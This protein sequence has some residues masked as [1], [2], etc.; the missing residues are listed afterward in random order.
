MAS[1]EEISDRSANQSQAA[2]FKEWGVVNEKIRNTP[3]EDLINP[4]TAATI[5]LE[6]A[7]AHHRHSVL[8]TR[9]VLS[10]TRLSSTRGG[11]L[12][13]ERTQEYMNAVQD[14]RQ[15]EFTFLK[16]QI[17]DTG[18]LWHSAGDPVGVKLVVIGLAIP[19]ELPPRD[20]PDT[21]A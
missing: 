20:Q 6:W 16:R 9:R 4:E 21:T 11:Q 14:A 3:L 13:A 17:I 8:Y 12:T 10:S 7:E 18:L 5:G 15:G 1:S 2:F 19:N